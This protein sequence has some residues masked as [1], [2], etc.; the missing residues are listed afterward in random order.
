MAARGR[1][2]LGP[3]D[4]SCNRVL[5]E[6]GHLV[7]P[8]RQTSGDFAHRPAEIPIHRLRN[9]SH[10]AT[11]A[12][13]KSLAVASR[14]FRARALALGRT[15]KQ[16]LNHQPLST[17]TEEER[18]CAG[19]RPPRPPLCLRRPGR[20]RAF[21]KR[22]EEGT[23]TKGGRGCAGG[24][25]PRPPLCLRRPG[26]GRAS[27]GLAGGFAGASSATATQKSSNNKLTRAGGPV[28]LT[29]QK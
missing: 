1:D 24:R 3:P 27:G 19:G 15:T 29:E 8:V 2:A 14:L 22:R 16:L 4:C 20:G 17:S 11:H 5:R 18:E 10:R 21:T 6:H 7:R 25:P 26:R 28:P 12:S 9:V 23:G 13:A